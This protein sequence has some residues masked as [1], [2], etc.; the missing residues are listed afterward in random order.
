MK[1]KPIKCWKKLHI[2]GLSPL[3]EKAVVKGKHCIQNQCEWFYRFG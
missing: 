2:A 3:L 1:L